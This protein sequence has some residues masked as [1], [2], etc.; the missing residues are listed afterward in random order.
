VF[1]HITI[2][3]ADRRAVLD[4]PRRVALAGGFRDDAPG[5]RTYGPDG[6]GV[7]APVADGDTAAAVHH[8]AAE[9]ELR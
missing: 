9:G 2:G 7:F 1:G 3:V 6:Q 4:E 8:R 5:R